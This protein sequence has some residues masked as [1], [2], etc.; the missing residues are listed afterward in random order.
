MMNEIE[1][2]EA[3]NRN[4]V[5]F[6]NSSSAWSGPFLPGLQKFALGRALSLLLWS[7]FNPLLSNLLNDESLRE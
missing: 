3:A 4:L 7:F 1:E 2:E 6:H 5:L